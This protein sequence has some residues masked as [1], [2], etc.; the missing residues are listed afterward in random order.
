MLVECVSAARPR[1]CASSTMTLLRLG[2]KAD[3]RRLGEMAGAAELEEVGPLV[4]V[5]A[6]RPPQFLRRH[7]HQLLAAALRDEVV[8]LLL[9]Q[10]ELAHDAAERKR[11]RPAPAE[12][13]AGGEDARAGLLAAR[14]PIADLRQRQQRAVAVAHGG[15]AVAQI[16][17]RRL[18]DDLVLARLVFRQRLVAIVLAAVERQVDVGVDQAGHDPAA[19][20]VDLLRVGGNRHARRA[21]PTARDA[22]AVD[23]DDRVGDRRAA[24]AVDHRAAD[25]RDAC[26]GRLRLRPADDRSSS[27]AGEHDCRAGERDARRHFLV[28]SGRSSRLPH[29][30]H[31]P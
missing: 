18:E 22:R 8:H 25:D 17:L 6:D 21:A 1:V 16:D 20:R 30:S 9:E 4:E 24:V 19:A 10:R 11:I 31:A 27:P 14:D 5:G 28:A 12:D 26:S 15:D 3:E 29:S 13:V 2:R 23:Q 7:R